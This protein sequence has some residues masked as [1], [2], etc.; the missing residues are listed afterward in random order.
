MNIIT[1]V[2][3]IVSGARVRALVRQ[4]RWFKPGLGVKRWIALFVLGV[5]FF[6][7]GIAFILV[8]AHPD[9]YL[10]MVNA[11]RIGVGLE[12]ALIGIGLGGMLVGLWGVFRAWQEIFRRTVGPNLANPEWL[13]RYRQ[14]GRGPYVV[15]IGGGHGLSTLLRGL[16]AYTSNL[17]AIVTVADDG[18]S[19]G[20]LRRELGILPPGDFRNCIAALADDEAL[21]TRLFQY[22]FSTGAGLQGHSFGN[23]FLSAMTEITGSFEAA[24]VEG[25]R[26]LG[27]QGR[28]L[29]STLQPLT[30]VADLADEKGQRMMQIKGESQ[31]S[32]PGW[33]IV[34]LTV[35][36]ESP[37]AYPEAVRSI[38]EADLVVLG[39]GSLYTSVVPNLLVP[40]LVQALRATSA[41]VV[42]VC[43]VVTQE[44]ETEGFT[45]RDHVQVIEHY[46]GA[47]ALNAVV[48]NDMF[49]EG[50]TL[51]WVVPDVP[52][53]D[54]LWVEQTDLV[55][56]E[57]PARHDSR[58]LA[59]VLIRLIALRE[60]P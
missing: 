56:R 44:G 5:M 24:L 59:Q 57:H 34:N 50:V 23:L 51:P 7:L 27:I 29:P 18:G 54:G 41:P 36:P 1:A 10:W 15:A 17:T 45:A 2:Q 19:S 58:K 20:R 16:K 49:P 32:R 22:R 60:Q 14:L 6:D 13:V 8:H 26:L 52:V 9:R 40:G 48:L 53:R 11:S 28:V 4:L 39:P 55:D 21:I 35:D 30:L 38:L 33:R 31:L 25:G 42:Y 12:V 46:L 37:P 3:K 47:S 43:N